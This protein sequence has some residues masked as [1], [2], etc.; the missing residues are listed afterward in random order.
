MP[1]S[2]DSVVGSGLAAN[3]TR[4]GYPL[5]TIDE[6]GTNDA[7]LNMEIARHKQIDR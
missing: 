7:L 1:S 5:E 4:V 2:G 6:M 3:R